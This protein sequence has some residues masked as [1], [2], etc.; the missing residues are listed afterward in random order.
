M[1]LQTSHFHYCAKH[2]KI[3]KHLRVKTICEVFF[4]TQYKS[5]GF[6][7]THLKVCSLICHKDKI[8]GFFFFG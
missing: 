3:M 8:M 7:M 1:T 4:L 2:L 5:L 6:K